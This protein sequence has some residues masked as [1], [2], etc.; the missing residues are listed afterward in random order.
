MVAARQNEVG[1]NREQG[2]LICDDSKP[3]LDGN[4]I[5]TNG[6]S[7]IR[8]E[9]GSEP[10]VKGNEVH[11]NGKSGIWLNQDNDAV[12][13]KFLNNRLHSNEEVGFLVSGRGQQNIE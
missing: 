1:G 4:Q 6:L 3:E 5:H 11:G 9:N 2:I 13:G 7:G 8:V 10:T 12:K